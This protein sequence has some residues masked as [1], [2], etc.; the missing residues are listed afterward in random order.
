MLYNFN[1]ELTGSTEDC[2]GV[3]IDEEGSLLFDAEKILSSHNKKEIKKVK[4]L[5]A[6]MKINGLLSTGT[7]FTCPFIKDRLFIMP[8][9]NADDYKGAAKCRAFL[10]KHANYLNIS[11]LKIDKNFSSIL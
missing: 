11:S 1:Y 10:E 3:F 5:V 9:K 6:S 2:L 8:I 4:D 7:C